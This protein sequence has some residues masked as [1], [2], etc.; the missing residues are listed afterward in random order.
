ME[1]KHTPWIASMEREVYEVDI[2][3]SEGDIIA[4]VEYLDGDVG[5]TEANAKL[6]AAAPD[7]LEACECAKSSIE[8]N[9]TCGKGD[10]PATEKGMILALL[11]AAIQKASE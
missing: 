6:I 5:E 9:R 7:L 11:E 3:N 8:N 1:T 2:I 4:R 10:D